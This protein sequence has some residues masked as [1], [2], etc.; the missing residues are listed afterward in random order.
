M[1]QIIKNKPENYDLPVELL[2]PWSTFVMA[3]ELPPPILKKMI[4][5]TD[6]IVA[7]P[8]HEIDNPGAGQLKDQFLPTIYCNKLL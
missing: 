6:E 3:T 1:A 2:Q 7:D 5:I 4:R 8:A